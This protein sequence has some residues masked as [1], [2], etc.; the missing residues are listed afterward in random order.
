MIEASW[1]LI[2]R[3][4][5]WYNVRVF[6][7]IGGRCESLSVGVRRGNLLSL[8]TFTRLCFNWQSLKGV[9]ESHKVPRRVRSLA[10]LASL[11]NLQFFI[12]KAK[13]VRCVACDSHAACLHLCFL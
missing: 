11:E 2:L 1:G 4:K 5:K 8:K 9:A 6:F 13:Y 7:E 12:Q 10:Y 3:A